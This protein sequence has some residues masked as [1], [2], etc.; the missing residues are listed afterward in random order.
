MQYLNKI[1]DYQGQNR[2]AITLG[3]FDG[4]HRGHQKLLEVV[5]DYVQMSKRQDE[6]IDSIVFAF[7]MCKFRQ[8]H[9]MRFEQIMLKEEQ[10][11][12]LQTKIDSLIHCAFDEQIRHMEAEVFIEE[13]IVKKFLAK[14]VVVGS[15][16]RF[17]Y[18]ARGNVHM[19]R[20]Y[21]E[22]YDYQVIEIQK[23]TY[24][25]NEISTTYIKSKIRMGNLEDANACLGY[26]Y[27][28]SGTVTSG[29]QL[30][31]TLGFPTMNV[32]VAE[33][34]ILPPNGVYVIRVEIRNKVYNGVAN[35]GVRPTV[36][37][38]SGIVVETHVF[39][40][41]EDAYGE[42]IKVYLLH[43]IRPEQKFTNAEELKAQV[44]QDIE[45]ARN[46]MK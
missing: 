3:K 39:D 16:F 13:V 11:L 1:D 46:M 4:F 38:N 37:E 22:K 23:E 33:E 21:A 12:F 2:S 18:K 8:E 44:Q 31:R 28:I 9:E 6:Q 35:I 30:G 17:G 7:D 34:K 26:D 36:L 5:K 45:V 43:M 40:Y 27:H 10:V 41:E 15:D 29:Q 42:D 19:L 14:Y 20:T 24:N 32:V 25:G